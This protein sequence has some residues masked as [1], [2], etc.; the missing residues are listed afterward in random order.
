MT[1]LM[2]V[3]LTGSDVSTQEEKPPVLKPFNVLYQS[4]Q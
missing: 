2:P 4:D 1:T 3:N